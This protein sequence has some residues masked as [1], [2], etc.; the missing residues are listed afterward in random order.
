MVCFV[1]SGDRMGG[2]LPRRGRQNSLTDRDM[3]KRAWLSLGSPDNPL[4]ATVEDQE[5]CWEIRPP[6]LSGP[7]VMET[8]PNTLTFASLYWTVPSLSLSIALIL[9]LFSCF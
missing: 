3:H 9:K 7:F 6:E 5:D 8:S 4:K 2:R 1:K